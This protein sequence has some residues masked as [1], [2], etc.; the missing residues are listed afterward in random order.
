MY[1]SFKIEYTYILKI[2]CEL[3]QIN[4]ITQI[5]GKEPSKKDIIW[6]LILTE[7]DSDLPLDFINIFLNLLE[8]KFDKLLE[9][10][11]QRND[12][13]IWMLYKYEGQCNMEFTPQDMKR[14]GENEITLCISCWESSNF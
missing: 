11:I 12:I 7:K 14:L 8:N 9:L 5:I 3:Q 4:N 1:R 10:G 2:D 13:T 6:E